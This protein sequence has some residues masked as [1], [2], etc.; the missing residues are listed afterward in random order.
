[1][2]S[3]RRGVVRSVGRRW[4]EAEE[5]EVDLDGEPAGE[6]PIRALAY[7]SLV[8]EL[9]PGR[10]VALNTTA[11]RRGLGTGGYAFV[12][13][14]LDR[15]PADP[16]AVPGHIVKARYTPQQVMVLGVDEQDSP[17]HH[18]LEDA[19][20]LHGMPVVAADL[21]SA[22][23]AIVAGARAGAAEAGTRPPRVVY[24]MTDS[25]ALPAAFSRLAAGLREAGWLAGIVTAGQAYGGDLEAVSMHSGLLAARV[26]LEADL[27]VVA[28][29]PGNAGTGTRWGFSGV[30][31]GEALNAAAVLGGRPVAALRV[32]GA[33][34]RP[35]HYGVSHHT[36]TA[37]G[38]VAL[39]AVD[40]VVPQLAGDLGRRVVAQV[41]ELPGRHRLVE[42]PTQDLPEA[43]RKAPVPLSTMG[44]GLE[45]DPAPFLAA[46][47][48]GAHA[49]RLMPGNQGG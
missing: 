23:P 47:A 29:G 3:W 31:V 16:P 24:L 34:D 20:D 42:V 36:M 22:V 4:G 38:R 18:R 13:A 7:T 32:S 8:G 33:D 46:A 21:H 40:V 48:A 49:A 14:P 27:V 12:I 19:D 28:Q 5:I 35:R 45:Q 26:V 1:M 43:L 44:R 11:L 41:H 6:G 25:A 9:G 2:M 17:H 39:A 30:S 10:Q 37:I 15:L